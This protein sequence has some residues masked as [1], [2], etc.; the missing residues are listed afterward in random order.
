[1]MRWLL[2]L[3]VVLLMNVFVDAEDDYP[4][5][6][7]AMPQDGVPQGR[8][9]GPFTLSSQVF[10][11]TEREYWIYVPAQYDAAKPAC[12]FVIQDGVGKARGWKLP[13]VLDNLIHS[14]QVPVQ[15]GV[16]VSPGVVPA[17]HDQAEARYNRSFEYDGMGDRYA[18]FLINELLPAVAE[19]YHF[20]DDPNDRAIAGS[21][22][23]A[24]CAFTAAWER[25]DQFRRVF[26]SIGTYVGLRGGNEYPTLIRKCE[27]KPLRIFLQDGSGDLDIYAG[28]W[29]HANQSMLSALQFAGY[30]VTHVWGE[31][32]HNGKHSAAIIA[33]A[34]RWLWRDYP[35]PVTTGKGTPRRMDLLIENEGWQLVSSGHRFTEGPA[36][37][38]TGELYFTD[39]PASR[40][41]KVDSGGAVTVFAEQ[42]NESNGL[43]FGP[44]GRLYACEGG[45]SQV[46]RYDMNGRREVFLS[47]IKGNDIV[48]LHDGSGFVSEPSARKI[49]HFTADGRKSVADEGID[50][51][52]GI[53]T[54]PDQTALT[55]TDTH[56][57]FCWSWRI[58]PDGRLIH[59]QEYG[60]LH[61]TDQLK[62]AADGLCVDTEGRTYVATSLGVQV[63]DQPG[64]V[65]LI[66][67]KPQ[68]A[69]LSNVVFAG[70]ERN[71]LYATCG[72]SV[73]RRKLNA[74]GY[75]PAS[76]PI[77]PPKPGL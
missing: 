49:W 12:L 47:G 65:N 54:S 45:S 4:V 77:K 26:S 29:W 72:D 2:S 7:E 42:T 21:S 41:H 19:K 69:W 62:S 3:S 56:G 53:I 66:I 73:Y 70:P 71:V 11:G 28:S 50:F 61:V 30:D 32:G 15:I 10:P 35:Q 38:P 23:G 67:E 58:Q 16:F 5:P 64:R 25:P 13:T 60:W 75:D 37:S 44:D 6:P 40:I 17:A 8:L 24:I 20:S 68:R 1:M 18:T 31:G 39:I 51:P 9:E 57:R 43:M 55:A 48:I 74:T 14:G 27:P 46:V 34:L 59:R 33:D 76:D 52:N 22:S 36:V 63:L